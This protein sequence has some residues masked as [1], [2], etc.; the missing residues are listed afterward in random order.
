M[1][2]KLFLILCALPMVLISNHADH[3]QTYTLDELVVES[4]PLGLGVSEISQSS[5]VLETHELIDYRA[6]T[7]ANTISLQP[8]I[9]QTY[10]AQMQ[11]VL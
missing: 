3:M 6:D 8:G 7:I 9:S 11:I 4:T 10:Y 1:K 5:N 2:F